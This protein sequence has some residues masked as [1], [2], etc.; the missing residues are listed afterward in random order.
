MLKFW[1]TWSLWILSGMFAVLI[2]FGGVQTY[3][4]RGYQ[5]EKAKVEKKYT[6]KLAALEKSVND[7]NSEIVSLTNKIGLE[8]ER[9]KEYAEQVRSGLSAGLNGGVVRLRHYWS[10]TPGPSVPQDAGASARAAEAERLRNESA[11]RIVGLAAECDARVKAYIDLYE[12]VR[13]QVNSP[14]LR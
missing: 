6:E 14:P 8:F 10:C 4:I 1:N 2:A 12:T 3:R 9:G 7:K 5:L 13:S 11:S